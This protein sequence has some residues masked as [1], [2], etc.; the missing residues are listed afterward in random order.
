MPKI[1]KF[2]A[3]LSLISAVLAAAL[4]SIFPLS[5]FLTLA[6]TFGTISYHLLMRL[7]IGTALG[8]PAFIRP[9][10]TK[11]WYKVRPWEHGVYKLLRVKRW[12]NKM[13]TYSPEDFSP[14]LHSW[15]DIAVNMCCAERVHEVISALSFVPLIAHIWFGAF[16]VFLATSLCGAA[17]DLSFAVIQRYNRM[18]IAKIAFRRGARPH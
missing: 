11:G 13:P 12:K 8:S 6:I 14:K 15:E 9:D 3:A 17:L 5:M 1:L 2:T 18:K 7:I 10:Y 4:Y 16:W